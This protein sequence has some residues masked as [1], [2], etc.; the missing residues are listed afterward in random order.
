MNTLPVYKFAKKDLIKNNLDAIGVN[1]STELIDYIISIFVFHKSNETRLYSKLLRPVL[2]RNY[3]KIMQCLVD[4]GLIKKTKN[5]VTQVMS[6]SYQLTLN[7]EITDQKTENIYLNRLLDESKNYSEDSI[8]KVRSKLISKYNEWIKDVTF[9]LTDEQIQALEPEQKKFL[10]TIM[11]GKLWYKTD[12]NNARTFTPITC[13]KKEIRKKI[14]IDGE[15]TTEV[16]L[17]SSFCQ[18]I[19]RMQYVFNADSNFRKEVEKGDVYSYIAHHIGVTRDTAKL[20]FNASLNA[21]I[22]GWQHKGI[23]NLFPNL[24][25]SVNEF[26]NAYGNCIISKI[27]QKRE[28]IDMINIGQELADL[29]IKHFMVHDCFIVKKKDADRVKQII[30]SHNFKSTIN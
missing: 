5:F 17:K 25:K 11:S 2:G 12:K 23:L 3:K 18:Q 27:L 26:R 14:L 6:M 4:S 20:Y 21:K 16:D 15:L 24:F 30:L 29:N 13:L 7:F 8:N 22:G 28:A 9:D 19:Y 1:N 10:K